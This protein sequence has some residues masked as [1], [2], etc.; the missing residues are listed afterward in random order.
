MTTELQSLLQLHQ[1]TNKVDQQLVVVTFLVT[2]C[3]EQVRRQQSEPR[4]LSVEGVRFLGGGASTSEEAFKN[5]PA[6]LFVFD[7]LWF[8]S[9]SV[10]SLYHILT[11][12]TLES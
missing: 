7:R 10:V 11:L 9:P 12:N 2:N 6:K 5:L 1:M 4:H 8:T 3:D